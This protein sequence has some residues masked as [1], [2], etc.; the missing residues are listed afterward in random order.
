MLLPALARPWR[1]VIADVD[2]RDWT[3]FFCLRRDLAGDGRRVPYRTING[4]ESSK[5][6]TARRWRWTGGRV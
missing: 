5:G 3:F 6:P 2:M 4:P 1:T